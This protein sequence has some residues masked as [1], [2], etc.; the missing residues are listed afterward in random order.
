MDHQTFDSALPNNMIGVVA[1]YIPITDDPFYELFPEAYKL[2]LKQDYKP[3]TKTIDGRRHTIDDNYPLII[4]NEDS[5]TVHWHQHGLL[6]RVGGPASVIIYPATCGYMGRSL[7]GRLRNAYYY[8]GQYHRMDGPAITYGSN[9]YNGYFIHGI[10]VDTPKELDNYAIPATI[11]CI[12]LRVMAEITAVYPSFLSL[13]V[14]PKT[15]TVDYKAWVIAR[16]DHIKRYLRRLK[17]NGPFHFITL[18]ENAIR[19]YETDRVKTNHVKNEA[20]MMIKG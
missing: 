1:S 3:D 6:H 17:T 12:P 11:D 15:P 16:T 4:V 9:R 20:G 10:P 13:A 18:Y 14:V 19:A 2:R 7:Q 8:K 5:L